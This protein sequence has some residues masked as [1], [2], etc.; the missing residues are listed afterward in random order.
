MVTCAEAAGCFLSAPCECQRPR[1]NPRDRPLKTYTPPTQTQSQ[2][3]RPTRKKNPKALRQRGAYA[4][5]AALLERFYPSRLHALYAVNAPW[6][7]R[8]GHRSVAQ[9]LMA[10]TR[11]KLRVCRERDVPLAALPSTLRSHKLSHGAGLDAWGYAAAPASAHAAGGETP[12]ATG[13]GGGGGAGGTA[14]GGGGASAAASDLDG[15]SEL[16]AAATTPLAPS[17]ASRTPRSGGRRVRGGQQQRH[18]APSAQ[19]GAVS[20]LVA[21]AMAA[22]FFMLVQRSALTV[23]AL[24]AVTGTLASPRSA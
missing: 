1:T 22:C 12:H 2:T 8:A 10:S 5:V 24:R 6:P 15:W 14:G 9:F 20:V 13:G 3:P 21:L 4:R 7:L 23:P 16:D 17:L 11:A 18:A 19:Q